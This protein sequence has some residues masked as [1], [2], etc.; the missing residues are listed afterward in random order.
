M[1]VEPEED[2]VLIELKTIINKAAN[3]YKDMAS[4]DKPDNGNLSMLNSII[5]TTTKLIEVLKPK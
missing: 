4:D 5:Q 3:I 2:K 1:T